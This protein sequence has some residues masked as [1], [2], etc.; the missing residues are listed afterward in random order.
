MP[1]KKEK[2]KLVSI[3]KDYKFGEYLP[4]LR[5][6]VTNGALELRLHSA[7]EAN[8]SIEAVGSR[9]SISAA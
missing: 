1:E 8:V 4:V 7:L 3:I 2:K 5:F 6:L 9:I